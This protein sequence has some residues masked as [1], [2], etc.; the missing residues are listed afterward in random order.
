MYTG[1]CKSCT[2][3]YQTIFRLLRSASPKNELVFGVFTTVIVM[4]KERYDD[5]L[6]QVSLLMFEAK[7]SCC[8]LRRR[9]LAVRRWGCSA[10]PSTCCTWR[11]RSATRRSCATSSRRPASPSTGGA[12]PR[13]SRSSGW[14]QNR[15]NG[16]KRSC[17]FAM[18]G[19]FCDIPANHVTEY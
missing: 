7:F 6:N 14:F 18:F 5:K 11:R 13:H 12:F 4:H 2:L 19:V 10:L 8:R 15:S 1:R 9:S 16:V 17:G 3:I